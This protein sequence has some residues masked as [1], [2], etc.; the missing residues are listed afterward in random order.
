LIIY[1]S[2]FFSVSISRS[3]SYFESFV[4]PPQISSLITSAYKYNMKTYIF[5]G[6][7]IE[8]S[9]VMWYNIKSVAVNPQ[10]GR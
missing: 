10:K 4:K 9:D 5:S 6:C 3:L 7:P 8:K 1:A 2:V